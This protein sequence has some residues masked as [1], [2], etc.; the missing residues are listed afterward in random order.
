MQL[1]ADILKVQTWQSLFQ[2]HFSHL[3]DKFFVHGMNSLIEDES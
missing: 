1:H 2:A 3:L